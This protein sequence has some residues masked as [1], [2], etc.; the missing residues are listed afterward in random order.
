MPP[1]RKILALLFELETD[2]GKIV[3]LIAWLDAYSNSKYLV[4]THPDKNLLDV[5]PGDML[6]FKRRDSFIIK[7]LKPWRTT[8]CKDDTQYRE[9]SCG[10]DWEMD[11]G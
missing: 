4:P 2:D 5:G 6:T 8:E 10:R 7:R 1:H 9:V 3:L 11:G